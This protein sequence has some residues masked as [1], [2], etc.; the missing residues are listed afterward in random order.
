[1]DEISELLRRQR[2]RKVYRGNFPVKRH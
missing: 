1:M 2:V